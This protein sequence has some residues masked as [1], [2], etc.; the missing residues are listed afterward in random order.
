MSNWFR[1][2]LSKPL[3]PE[4][5]PGNWS[6]TLQ[7]QPAY[8][9]DIAAYIIYRSTGAGF[10]ILASVAEPAAYYSDPGLVNHNTYYYMLKT[11]DMS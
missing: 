9:P 2:A 3:K 11:R 10:N 1:T 6:V 4:A 5:V 8:E 7:W